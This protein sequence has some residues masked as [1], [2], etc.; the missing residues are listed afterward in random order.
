MIVPASDLAGDID[1]NGEVDFADFLVV[2]ANFGTE[3]NPPGTNG[4]LNGDGTVDFPDF[5]IL[6]G[7]FGQSAATA[8][9]VPEPTGLLLSLFGVGILG[10]ARQ[11]RARINISS[12]PG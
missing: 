10:R 11:R 8:A 7:N 4:D 12:Q 6:S 2:S 5:L 1:A 9:S 3:V